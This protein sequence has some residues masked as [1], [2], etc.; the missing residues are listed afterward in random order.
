MPVFEQLPGEPADAF[1]QL[2]VHRDAGPSRLFRETAIVTG[3]SE[4]TLRRRAERWDWQIR[5][6]S[7]DASMLKKIESERT[8][9]TL[10]RQT[11]QLREFRDLQLDRARRLGALADLMMEFVRLSLVQHHEN[12]LVLNVREFSS[13]L[14]SSTKAMELSMDTEAISLGVTEFLDRYLD[15]EN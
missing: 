11:E 6:N 9:Q 10:R 15:F 2:L 3:T 1:A 8:E 14:S 4:S 5:L 13:V 12:G 7:Y